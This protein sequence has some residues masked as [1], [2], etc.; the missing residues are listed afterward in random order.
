[1]KTRKTRE[2]GRKSEPGGGSLA[3]ALGALTLGASAIVAMPQALAASHCKGEGAAYQR[4]VTTGTAEAL[5]EYLREYPTC[6]L[7][8]S[9][10]ALLNDLTPAAGGASELG[11]QP[12]MGGGPDDPGR[13]DRSGYN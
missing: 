3:T 8:A 12:R 4:A 5:Q 1:M 6:S 2:T 9:V 10:F 11:S 7:S 13:G